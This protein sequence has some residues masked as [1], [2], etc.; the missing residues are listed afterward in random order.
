MTDRE[1][2]L[3]IMLDKY[4]SIGNYDRLREMAEADKDGRVV[5]LPCKVG[6]YLYEP[7]YREGYEI[8]SGRINEIVVEIVSDMGVYDAKDIGDT[9]FV[10]SSLL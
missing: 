6:E 5:V 8:N 3:S 1:R 9:V 7:P 2:E 4:Q 10:S